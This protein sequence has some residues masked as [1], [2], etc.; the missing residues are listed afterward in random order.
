[1]V[2]VSV[3]TEKP[4]VSSSLRSESHVVKG[5]QEASKGDGFALKSYLRIFKY[6]NR[7]DY[8]LEAIGIIAAIG[9]GV[10]LALV[11]V[12]IGQFMTVFGESSLAITTPEELMSNARTL[13]LYFVYIGIARLG[14][15][16]IYSSLFTFVAY[17]LCR[18]IRHLYLRSAISMEIGF[19][20]QGMPG[21]ISMQA[22][23]N[24]K[25]IQS[26]IAEK[27]G[28]FIQSIAT[29]AAAFVIAF[30]AHWKL[31]LIIIGI[32]PVLVFVVGGIGFVEATYE[33]NILQV[34]AQ[35]GG[36]AE[37]ILAGIRT[38]KA[39]SLRSRVIKQFESYLRDAFN[40]GKKKNLLYGILFGAEY[41]VIFGGIALAFWQGI[42]RLA[43][44]EIPNI[45]TVFT[46]LFSVIVAAGTILFI[47]PNNVAFIRAASA[48]AELFALMDRASHIDPFEE[49]GEKPGHIVGEIDL[50]AIKFSY[51]TRPNVPILEDFS[52]RVPAGRVTALV[53]ASGSGKS[54]IIG[55][56]ERWYNPNAGSI[57]LDGKDIKNL[58]LVWL[59]TN[60]RLVQQ[61]P[62]L[63]NGSVFDNIANG[64]VGTPWEN[65]SPEIQRQHI[66]EAAKLAFAHE[67]I[68]SLPQKYDTRIGERGGLLSGGQKQRVAIARS[69]VS[70]PKI[71]LLDE[72]TSALDPHA[73]GIVQ[74]ALDSASKDRTTIVIAHKLATIRHADNIVVM[75]KGCIVEQGHHDELVAR[76]GAYAMLVKAQDLSPVEAKDESEESTI[77]K[78][79]NE[80]DD[81]DIKH[82]HSLA[83]YPTAEARRLAALK[84]RENFDLF[85]QSGLIRSIGKLA[86]RTPELRHWYFILFI[87]CM[88]GAAVYPGQALLF[89]NV[90]DII[91]SDNMVQR[92][93][94]VALMFFVIAV[95]SLLSYF[96]MGWASNVIAQTMSVKSRREILDSI[97][98]QDLRF[99]DRPENT[100]G[101]LI[102]RLDSH[103]QAILELMG[104]NIS[105]V[106]MCAMNILA[107][108]ILA[109]VVSWEL[110]LVG[111]FV[112]VPPIVL[113]GYARIRLDTKMESDTSKR[114]STSASIAS[115]N[116]MAIRTVSSLAIENRVLQKYTDE[117]DQAVKKTSRSM[118]HMM[119][120]FSLTQAIEFFVLALGFWWGAKLISDGR[121]NFYQ[122][123]VSFL[124]VYFSG[125]AAGQLFSFANSFTKA[126][127]AANYYF[128]LSE[129]QPTIG[130]TDENR[131]IGPSNGCRSYDFNQVQFSY[132]LAPDTRVLKG[133]SFS[134]QPD[135]F[136]AFVGAS[137]CGKSTIISLLER[138]YDSTSGSITIDSTVPLTS[139]NPLLYRR[140]LALVQQE[141][142][143]FPGSIRENISQ[144]MDIGVSGTV[145]EADIE[146]ACRAAN[147]WDFVSSLPEG[148]NTRCGTGGS[149]LSGGQRQRIAIARALVRRPNV[150]LL[151]EATSALDTESERIVQGALMNAAATGD[152]ITIAVAHRLSTVRNAD[153]I[154]VFHG[155]RIVEAGTHEEL[156]ERGELYAKMCEAQKLDRGL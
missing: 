10:A 76:E 88:G 87:C 145:P 68:L 15:T 89:A 16:Y 118:F 73:E 23:S 4:A 137:G 156:I 139:I 131:E 128:W 104:F 151:D 7:T 141:P 66:E 77:E 79:L 6:G 119:V 52:L 32:V 95:G 64:L 109:I 140:R 124:G 55:L 154:F 12:V 43:S 132:P 72:A 3:M 71:L 33:T 143:L 62:V 20:D 59:R 35:A 48:A 92:G 1:M 40:L 123:I 74:Q 31:T 18:N 94:F 110:G 103:P 42:A 111:V 90:M 2:M 5:D 67:F 126:N 81:A 46:V 113:S 70:N 51:P 19:F 102:S 108:S 34:Y 144:G 83:R 80:G 57:K 41:F 152:R 115:E 107:S 116:V 121:I 13:A 114:F 69:I 148:L 129:L 24:G 91:T 134:I 28:M 100:V 25:L 21:S 96:V 127:Q 147:A 47:A 11:N 117:L 61:E 153:R 9:S 65:E 130:E 99:F 27:L 17:R 135:Q 37:N 50:Q 56:L 30:V 54:T 45:G 58:N 85:K 98:R 60:I 142:T 39:F 86:R 149:Q 44:G 125:Q 84:E 105:L 138:F 26:G 155:G 150:I 136:V 22:T 29:F 53:G 120:W 14:L 133:V 122:F 93:N 8:A 75:S 38:V 63:F 106:I 101:A 78:S 146:T 36:Y 97:L 112:G 49:S 82:I